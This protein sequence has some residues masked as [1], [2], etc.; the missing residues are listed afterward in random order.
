[1]PLA[2]KKYSTS[3]WLERSFEEEKGEEGLPG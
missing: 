2:C 1:L 3:K